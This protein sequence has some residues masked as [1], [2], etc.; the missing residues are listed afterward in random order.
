[1]NWSGPIVVLSTA[2]F[3]DRYFVSS[4][5]DW[6]II[7]FG[8]WQATMA[9]PSIVEF[10]LSRL[11][12]CS[13]GWAAPAGPPTSHLATKGC[14]FDFCAKLVDARNSVVSGHVC[15]DCRA[16][17]ASPSLVADTEKLIGFGWLGTASEP[18]EI[19]TTAKKLGFDLFRT[20]G[21]KPT[22]RERLSSLI[23]EE[24]AKTAFVVVGAVAAAAVM[25]V[26]GL[27]AG[28][29]SDTSSDRGSAETT[30]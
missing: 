6:A 16:A 24:S 22:V 14:I 23:V 27:S 13:M 9:P 2:T 17:I 3:T 4:Q 15:A 26:L 8:D 1:L 12:T 10:F 19:A 7:A 11:I 29:D 25:F 5:A 30:Q 20:R 21:I 28:K 18:A